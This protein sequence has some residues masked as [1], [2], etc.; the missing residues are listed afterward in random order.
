MAPMSAFTHAWFRLRR[1]WQPRQPLFWLMCV[2]NVASSVMAWI[3]HV[4]PP[5]GVAFGLLAGLALANAAAAMVLL[6]RLMAGAPG[7]ESPR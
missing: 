5:A 7:T 6:V 3:L 4:A 1:V 2:F